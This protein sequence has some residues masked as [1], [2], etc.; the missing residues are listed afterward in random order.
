MAMADTDE[1]S[2]DPTFGNK[3]GW[4]GGPQE[5]LTVGSMGGGMSQVK[6]Q[7]GRTPTEA[8]LDKYMASLGGNPYSGR[9]K[10]NQFGANKSSDRRRNAVRDAAS[11]KQGERA[12]SDLAK[13]FD[14]ARKMIDKTNL[15]NE[16]RYEEILG[17]LTTRY[18]HAM[19]RISQ[20][21]GSAR[22]DLEERAAEGLGNIQAQL[23][24][25]G[26]GNSTIM[27]SF[28]QRSDRD[29]A[30]EQARIS[31]QQ[32]MREVETGAQ[33]SGDMA[34]FKER[35][36][37]VAPDYMGLMELANKYGRGGGGQEQ[38]GQGYQGGG[39]QGYQGG[40]QAPRMVAPQFLGGGAH[41]YAGGLAMANMGMNSYMARANRPASN[42]YPQRNQAYWPN[43][44]TPGAFTIEGQ[45]TPM[46]ATDSSGTTAPSMWQPG[47]HEKPMP[48]GYAPDIGTGEPM[49]T[50][51]MGRPLSRE[52]YYANHN[53][54]AS[55]MP[56][57]QY[58]TTT[59]Q[60]SPSQQA[61]P[62]IFSYPSEPGSLQS[63]IRNKAAAGW[64]SQFDPE[65]WKK[66]KN[67]FGSV[68]GGIPG[69]DPYIQQ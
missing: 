9:R 45:Q 50:G 24:A 29:L 56:Q 51:P 62:G 63:G 18:D 58:V 16:E 67:F 64:E 3:A 6:V 43:A 42:R 34:A 14:E 44:D 46:G 7:R 60:Q 28:M 41:P 39:Q 19:A 5:P 22:A 68:W 49:Q 30:R 33:L 55:V 27:A 11:A 57:Q 17:D 32:A 1:S 20:F 59:Q 35:R 10:S 23:S 4:L 8:D 48:G 66:V 15:K 54:G 2:W 26:L 21:G 65:N 31:E 13:F 47:P 61:Q 53:S 52:G 36:E 25:R 40:Y 37:D 69:V 12:K 38:G